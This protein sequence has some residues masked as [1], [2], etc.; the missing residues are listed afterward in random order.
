MEEDRRGWR[1]RRESSCFFHWKR[2]KVVTVGLRK[3]GNVYC[4]WQ[5]EH[6]G[7]ELFRDSDKPEMCIEIQSVPRSK[8]SKSLL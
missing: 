7:K 6:K 1:Q 4:G 2:G 3:Q 8:H 5:Q